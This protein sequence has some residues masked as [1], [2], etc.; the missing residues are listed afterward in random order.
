MRVAFVVIL[1]LVAVSCGEP[2][3]DRIKRIISARLDIEQKKL[4]RECLQD[5]LNKANE[6]VDSLIIAR[7]LSDTTDVIIKPTRPDVP[8]L[9]IP[10]IDTLGIQPLFEKIDSTSQ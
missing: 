7:A 5:L 6:A 1:S 2:E 3:L 9:E 10:D 8:S 4:E